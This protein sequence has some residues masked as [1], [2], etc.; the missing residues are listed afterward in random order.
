MFLIINTLYIL[1]ITFVS[2]NVKGFIIDPFYISKQ[3][4]RVKSCLLT[5]PSQ[6]NQ[7]NLT[8]P[9]RLCVFTLPKNH[10]KGDF[11]NWL[12]WVPALRSFSEGEDDACPELAE[13]VKPVLGK[14]EIKKRSG[15]KT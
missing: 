4:N 12:P 11:F 7:L 8:K 2:F 9:S 15:F 3:E 5:F 6:E 10:Q 13:G 14:F 1:F